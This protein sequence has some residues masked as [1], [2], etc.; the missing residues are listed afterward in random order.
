M[1]EAVVDRAVEEVS[2]LELVDVRLVVETIE[3][4]S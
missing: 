1:A 3:E 4:L 2:V